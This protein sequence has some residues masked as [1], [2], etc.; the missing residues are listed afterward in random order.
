MDI[1]STGLDFKTDKY[2]SISIS[3]A[4]EDKTL[5]ELVNLVSSGGDLEVNHLIIPYQHEEACWTEK[6]LALIRL[7]LQKVFKNKKAIKI[8]A[9]CKFDLKFNLREGI[10]AENVWDIQTLAHLINENEPKGLHALTRK[11]FPRELEVL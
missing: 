2:L 7:F 5:P 8:L 3:W 10:E 6:E 9:N 4:A 11:Y 1:E